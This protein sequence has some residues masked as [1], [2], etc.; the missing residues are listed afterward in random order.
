[1]S[2]CTN[3]AGTRGEAPI[4]SVL[5]CLFVPPCGGNFLLWEEKRGKGRKREREKRKK[6]EEE[7]ER[8]NL[9]KYVVANN[10]KLV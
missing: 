7:R 3:L 9:N 5:I 1:M 4:I 6:E 2:Q 8:L 10:D